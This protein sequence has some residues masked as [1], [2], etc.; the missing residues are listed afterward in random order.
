[1]KFIDDNIIN[2]WVSQH[3]A[4]INL[5]LLGQAEGADKTTPSNLLPP[6]TKYPMYH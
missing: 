6:K 1:M 5:S 4:T 2:E 3:Y